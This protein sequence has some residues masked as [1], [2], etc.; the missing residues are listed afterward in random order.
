MSLFYKILYGI[1]FTPWE[2]GLG[3]QSVIAQIS[4]MFDREEAG[5]QPPYGRAL[6]LGCGSG[7]HAVELAIRGWQVTGVDSVPAALDRARARAKQAGVEVCF[8]QGDVAALHAT[9]VGSNFRLIL[10]FG[11]VHGLTKDQRKAVGQEVS[12]LATADASVLMLAFAPRWRGPLPRGM[13]PTDIETTYPG[14]K[15]TDRI[16]QNAELPP[17][18]KKLGANPCWY[19]LRRD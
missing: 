17:F 18:L 5:C 2:E 12:A 11:T 3:Q 7:I 19:R 6:D 1:G 10:D 9:G 16:V 8:L 15:I 13:S 4:A 14:W